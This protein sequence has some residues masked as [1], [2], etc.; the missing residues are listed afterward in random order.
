M[1][2]FDRRLQILLDDERYERLAAEARRRSVPVAHVVREAL[3][4]A[5]PAPH[6]R[7]HDAAAAILAAPLMPVP[8][9]EDLRS[10]LEQLRGRRG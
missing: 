10:E 5:L 9:P 6:R 3:D 7:R 8:A 2:M 1:C 4:V